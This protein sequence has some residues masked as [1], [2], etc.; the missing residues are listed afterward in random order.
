MSDA[1]LYAAELCGVSEFWKIGGAQSIA[2]LAFGTESIDAV[3]KITGPGNRFVTEAKRQVYGVVSI[4]MLAGPSEIMIYA[5]ASSDPHLI[6]R[7]LLSQAEHDEDAACILISESPSL[8]DEVEKILSEIIPG[9]ERRDTITQSLRRNSLALVAE[10]GKEAYALINL[11]APEHLEILAKRPLEEVLASVRNAGAIFIG[12]YAPE[13][14]GDY[15]AGPNHTLPTLGCARFTSPLGVYDFVKRS[16]V[17]SFGEEACH[18]LI[19]DAALIARSE[20]FAAHEAS[21][22]ARAQ[23]SRTKA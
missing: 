18:A 7:D 2:A 16:S 3:G 5:D 1:V 11:Y 14:I 9:E 20:G 6:A 4:D 10:A 23:K 8:I 15:L 21:V 12:E 13:P 22:R 17:I 19:E